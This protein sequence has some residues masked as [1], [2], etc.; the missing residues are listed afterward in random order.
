MDK[1]GRDRVDASIAIDANATMRDVMPR[2]FSA[3]GLPTDGGRDEEF[4][5][6][7]NGLLH[8]RLPNFGWRRAA[9]V[10]HDAHHLLTGFHCTPTGEMQMAAWEFAA[11]RLPHPGATAFC[12]PLVGLGAILLPRRTFAAF[13]RG[14]RGSS[15]YAATLS[16]DV[17]ALPIAELRNRFAP[18]TPARPTVRDVLAYLRLVGLSF[19][20]IL[21]PVLVPLLALIIVI[22]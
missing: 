4:W 21:V 3:N 19:A 5:Y 10:R 1:A 15:L 14:R 7:G 13:L 20:L 6:L 9:I 16:S 22:R 11:G 12:L 18:A 2:F 17:L 8:I